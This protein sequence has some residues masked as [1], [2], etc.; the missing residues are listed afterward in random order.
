MT[1]H[2]KSALLVFSMIWLSTFYCDAQ[3]KQAQFV[4]AADFNPAPLSFSSVD[5]NQYVNAVK[6]AKGAGINLFMGYTNTGR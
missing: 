4:I 5:S 3:W 6:S 2:I 1:I